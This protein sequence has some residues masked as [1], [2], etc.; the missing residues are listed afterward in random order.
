MKSNN[1][2]RYSKG[3]L[4]LSRITG[5]AMGLMLLASYA[6]TA[7]DLNLALAPV[8]N[9]ISPSVAS[10]LGGTVITIKGANFVNGAISGC[11]QNNATKVVFVNSTTLNVT[12]PPSTNHA[13]GKVSV[14]VQ[15]PDNQIFTLPLALTYDLP[16]SLTSVAPASAPLAGG[17]QVTLS[18]QFFRCGAL[19]P[20]GPT[21]LFGTTP[22][23]SVVF[24]NNTTLTATAPA[25]VAGTVDVKET[26]TDGLSTVLKNGFTFSNVSITG[27]DP[28]I[29]PIAGGNTV[30]ITG[31]GFTNSSVVTFGGVASVSV[32]FINS[33]TLH[34][35]APAHVGGKVEVVVANLGG[36]GY[37]PAGYT[38]S[39]G[40]IVYTVTPAFGSFQGGTTVT[41]SGYSLTSVSKVMFGTAAGTITATGPNNLTVTTPPLS[42]PSNPVDISVT[43]PNGTF[44][45]SGGFQYQLAVQNQ[46][47]D[48]GYPAIP[49]SNTLVVQGGKGP[50]TWAVTSGSL[51]SGLTLNAATGEV[52]GVPD[53]NYGTY[54]FGV[55]VQ[56][57]ST[58]PSSGSATYTFNILFGFSPGPIP[59]SYFGLIVFDQNNW[60][61]VPFGALGKGLAT[62]WPFIEPVKGQFNWTV[63]DQ[64]VALAQT[65]RVPGSTAPLTLYW[66]NSNVPQWAA[67]NPKS[68]SN[69]PGTSPPVIACTSMVNNIQDFDDFMTALV[70]RYQGLI[71]TYELW[72][73]PNVANVYTGSLA[74][75][76]TLTAHAYNDIRQVDPSALI[77]S[78][79]STAAPYL[80]AYW[81]TPGA[82]Q[83]VDGVAIHGY[84]D[85]G[86]ADVPEAITGFKTVNV[87]LAMLAVPGIGVKP[88]W[89]TE[90]SWG[91]VKAIT[92]PDMRAAFVVRSFLLHWSAGVQNFFWYGWDAPNWG[93]LWYPPPVGVTPAGIAYNTVFSWMV[94]A[95][96]PTPCTANGGSTYSAVYSCQLTK[97][98]YNALAVWDTN[99]S[100]N[101]GTC[102]TS[103]YKPDPQYNQYRDV[104]GARTA[105]TP[106]QVIQIGAKPILLENTNVP[107][108]AQVQ[109]DPS[110]LE[111]LANVNFTKTG[112]TPVFATTS[113]QNASLPPV[114]VSPNQAPVGPVLPGHLALSNLVV[115]PGLS[116]PVVGTPAVDSDAT[117]AAGATQVMQWADFRLQVFD[118]TITPIGSAVQGNLFWS[119][120]S[121]CSAAVGADGIVQYDKNAGR[122]LVAMRTGLNDECVAISQTSDATQQYH[123]YVVQYVDSLHTG[124]QMDF[125]HIAVWPDAYYL[126]FDMLDPANNFVPKYAVACALNRPAM[127]AGATSAGAVCLKTAYSNNT[128]FFH[129]LPADVDGA[130][131]PPAGSP[132]YIYTFA[133]PVGSAHYHLYE[134]RFHAD[135][136][137]PGNSTLVGPLQV[138]TTTFNTLQP[139]CLAGN[140]NCIPQPPPATTPLDS[141]GGYLN[142]RA[143][144][145]NFGS[146]ES[147]LITQA[148]QRSA[149]GPVGILWYEVRNMSTTPSLFQSNFFQPDTFS[150]WMSSVAMD[151]QGNMAMGYSISGLAPNSYYNGFPG[152]ALT[153]RTPAMGLNN[154]A[155]E[156]IVFNGVSSEVPTPPKKT[157]R[158][159]SVSDMAID[160]VDQCTFWFTGQYEPSPGSY[161]WATQIVSFRFTS[162]H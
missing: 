46:G 6:S 89:D 84:P 79:S 135:F 9:S 112:L 61:T 13:E 64:Y 152:L 59:A 29:G 74:D 156:T 55:S 139:A 154:L 120:S 66:T 121:P 136:V 77:L 131:P 87:K 97:P 115:K 20:G 62:T 12:T 143:S 8:I 91:G 159:G 83:D 75:L 155:T 96:M 98:G 150:R 18:G 147:V 106:G 127:L 129:L 109:A 107:P 27:V 92:D 153:G 128:G 132:N 123:E 101:N 21:V 39:S 47:M 141:V 23:T 56:D 34:A 15:N 137:T 26:N 117:L 44:T 144:Y 37:L 118:K 94:G 111:A 48:D 104:L 3:I 35:R 148:A 93:T 38:F 41:L 68:C 103:N 2:S 162:C 140:F 124:Y 114:L 151:K 53:P 86:V 72:N 40:P 60:P 24:N 49:Y 81:N 52:H 16:P 78:P 108:A 76:V 158:W 43:N 36:S 70:T 22:A 17:T 90:S 95:S 82:P 99:Q 119:A 69:Y 116:A 149:S 73:E 71:Q 157:G 1:T 19:C 45:L 57:S 160:P 85:V 28:A 134:Y 5:A 32:Q 14:W 142:Y 31:S 4:R 30:V 122:W 51:P 25:H 125:P 145:R 130:N 67:V 7:Q 88:I 100:C 42:G 102:T 50:Y 133:K 80:Q 138:D 10:A 126:V 11:G 33:T 161:N 54:T 110:L 63:L 105:I 58:P 146:H 113:Q 65:H